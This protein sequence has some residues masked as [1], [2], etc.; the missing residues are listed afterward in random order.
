MAP[1]DALFAA[2]PLA[3][4]MLDEIPP[5]YREDPDFRAVIYCQAREHERKR[6]R[7]DEV[8][9]QFFPATADVLLGAWEATFRMT[10]A[11]PGVPIEERRARVG[12]AFLRALA[13]SSG[14]A[15][16]AAL[17]AVAGAGTVYTEF[18]PQVAS[19][20]IPKHTV[21]IEVPSAVDPDVA[22]RIERVIR[23]FTPANTDIDIVSGAGFVL[24]ISQLDTH[25]FGGN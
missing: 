8:R 9:R 12:E 19:N 21:R 11:P 24:D 25:D 10:I 15:W 16:E 4:E 6:E 2:C 20:V 5:D 18:D 1:T 23:A 22:E 14:A 3:V 17:E 7:I 13:G